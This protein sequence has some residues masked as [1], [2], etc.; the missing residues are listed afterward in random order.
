MP[1]AVRAVWLATAVFLLTI[2]LLSLV[3]CG[4]TAI[5]YSGPL[6]GAVSPA[7]LN[8]ADQ[9]DRAAFSASCTHTTYDSSGKVVAV[10]Q[11]DI[12]TSESSASTVIKAQAE[13]IANLVAKLPAP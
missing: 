7:T 8:L 11:V 5:E 2:L 10:D 9:K 6:C 12:S 3:G 13:A 1:S 4:G